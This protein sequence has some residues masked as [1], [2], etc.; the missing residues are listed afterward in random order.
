MKKPNFKTILYSLFI[1]IFI[2]ASVHMTFA[3]DQCSEP[4][5]IP[6]EEIPGPPPECNPENPA[7]LPPG[8]AIEFGVV[9]GEAPFDWSITGGTGIW[10]N[11]EY[12]LTQLDDAPATV[13]FYAD[14]YACAGDVDI[15]ITSAHPDHDPVT[16]SITIGVDPLEWIEVDPQPIASSCSVPVS[17]TGGVPPYTWSVDGC[18]FSLETQTPETTSLP[19]NIL[20]AN[21]AG[22]NA[23]ITV[24][25]G[26]GN[27]VTGSVSTLKQPLEWVEVSSQPIP[28]TTT[29]TVSVTGG[30]PPF[31]WS[32]SGNGFDLETESPQT[33]QSRS[34]VLSTTSACGPGS[35]TVVDS[36]YNDVTGIVRAESGKWL[37]VG[38][39]GRAIGYIDYSS[40]GEY[41][42][43]GSCVKEGFRYYR[44][45]GSGSE[46][47]R[48][49]NDQDDCVW[50]YDNTLVDGSPCGDG[51]NQEEACQ[52]CIDAS[53]VH[54]HLWYKQVWVCQ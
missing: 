44:Y 21:D 52:A 9:L 47:V 46:V 15:T 16:C 20:Y 51:L 54:F 25:D 34:N 2:L 23:T 31:T 19:E 38:E 14:E 22:E 11:P 6:G 3:D 8:T 4:P 24:T 37:G 48:R 7:V 49:C 18:N 42:G 50:I 43:T 13:A 45:M 10:L 53:N 17:I 36:C 5:D 35:I 30:T 33:T 28:A 12:T 27:I 40:Y 32:V 26:C 29:R 39:L 1:S 41:V